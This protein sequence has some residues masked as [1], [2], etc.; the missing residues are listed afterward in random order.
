LV[1]K[2]LVIGEVTPEAA[3]GGPLGLVEDGDPI[4]IDLEARTANLDVPADVLEQRRAKFHAPVHK[5][6]G[7]VSVYR[8]SVQPL[9][10]GATLID[11]R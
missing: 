10:K 1:N 6:E 11:P 2:G 3:V 8:R 5:D 9:S 7:W 4:S